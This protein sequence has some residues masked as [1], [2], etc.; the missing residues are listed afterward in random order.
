MSDLFC[1]ATLIVARHGEAEY[2]SEHVSDDGG[3]LTAAGRVQ[4][5]QLAES[6]RDRRIAAIWCSDM[7]RAVQTAEIV[8]AALDVPVRVRP[9]L[10]EFSVGDLAGRPD[11]WESLDRVFARWMG[12]D[13]AAGCPGAESGIDVVRRMRVELETLAD[14]SRGET[15]AVISHGGVIGLVLPQLAS[16]VRPDHSAGRAMANCGTC[17]ISVDADGWV[18]RTWNNQ[19]LTDTAGP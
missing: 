6:L 1:P 12:G 18:L 14:Q 13:L 5:K 3:S 4:A 8:A 15:V 17:E 2:D 7:A 9:G 19:P 11:G 10:R 16:N